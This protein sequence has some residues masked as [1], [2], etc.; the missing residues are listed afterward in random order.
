MIRTIVLAPPAALPYN[1]FIGNLKLKRRKTMKFS[2]KTL[3]GAQDMTVGNP[4]AVLLKFAIP[5]LIGNFAQQL[6]NTVDA[7]VVGHY[8][9]DTALAA[10]GAA[11]PILNLLLSL[12]MGVATGAGIIVAQFFGAKDR[13][14]LSKSVGNIL[15]LTVVVGVAV[16][17]IGT[18]AA[19]PF[20]VL[21]D[22]PAEILQ[23]ASDYL[24]IFM[25]GFIGCAFYN[26]GSGI[27]RGL[28]DSVMP[29]IYLLICCVI[30][31]VLDVAFVAVFH[32]GVAGVALATI[33]AQFVSAVLCLVRLRRMRSVLDVNLKL[34][35]PDRRLCARVV[36]IGMPAGL[37][38]AVFSC[39]AL[40]V[41]SL[42]NTFGTSV[43]AASTVIM[44]VDGF[45]MMPNFS[46]GNAMTT[47]VGQNVG[48]RKT[49][50]VHESAR[51]GLKIALI[52]CALLVLC[53]LFFGEALMR[54]FT[55]TPEVID[56]GVRMLRLLAVGYMAVAVT[57]V[58]SGIMRGAG[59]T[60]TPML[61][62]IITTVAVR[63]PIAYLL[64]HFTKSAAQPAGAPESLFISLMVSWVLGAVLSAVFYKK[65]AWKKKA[66]AVMGAA[67]PDEP[68][69]NAEM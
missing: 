57:Q 4:T 9:G 27:L 34:M 30:N 32:M 5:L 40:V 53:I 36:T 56:I 68:A 46:Y 15:F 35:R 8:I 12:F 10:V 1:A 33:I 63:V 42:T 19:R 2:L 7:I 22:T 11:N 6:Y 28:G 54:A 48:A 18:L 47:Y 69:Q 52:T 39:A 31:I 3:F 41:Q 65:G 20:L 43:I 24:A 64:A 29:L 25:I 67:L 60:V 55:S 13:Q 50:R 38:Q 44:R 21:L 49:Q 16:T 59:D 62:S 61:I 23:G 51:Y 14:M 58:L 26:M 45:A 37:T 17:L 66:G